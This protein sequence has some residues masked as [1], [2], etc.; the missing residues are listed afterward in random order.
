MLHAGI[1]V[2]EKPCGIVI[3]VTEL[4]GSES[5]SQVYGHLHSLLTKPVMNTTGTNEHVWKQYVGFLY[6]INH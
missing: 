5:K 3:N 6:T 1:L 2:F 4:Y